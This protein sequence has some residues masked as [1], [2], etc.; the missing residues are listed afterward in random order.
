MHPNILFNTSGPNHIIAVIDTNRG[1][2]GAY[3]LGFLDAA[4]HLASQLVKRKVSP[5]I[6]IYGALYLYRHGLELGLKALLGTYHYEL[7]HEDKTFDGHDLNELWTQ[8]EPQMDYLDP[9]TYPDECEYFRPDAIK[10]IGECVKVIHGVDPN[11]QHIRYGEDLDGN[12]TMRNVRTVN[13]EVLLDM[14]EGTHEWMVSVLHQR[15]EVDNFLR[16]RRGYFVSRRVPKKDLTVKR[17]TDSIPGGPIQPNEH[18]VLAVKFKP[19]EI[20]GAEWPSELAGLSISANLYL[21]E[22][23]STYVVTTTFTGSGGITGQGPVFQVQFPWGMYDENEDKKP[24]K[25]LLKSEL[26][27]YQGTSGQETAS[28]SNPS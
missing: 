14:C 16:H 3:V 18:V 19:W 4:H 20:S 28:A 10:Y 21:R 11:G 17:L 23:Q 15:F 22:K 1:D 12:I 8:L 5:D 6:V 24:F 26:L 25:R 27:G 7:E 9:L 13:L 2:K